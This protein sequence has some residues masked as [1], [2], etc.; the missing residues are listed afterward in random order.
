MEKKKK[1]KL[2][3][4]ITLIVS[5]SI[6][7]PLIFVPFSFGTIKIAQ[8]DTGGKATDVIVKDEIAYV[9]DTAD[10]NPGGLVMINVSKKTH[11]VVVGTYLGSGTPWAIDVENHIAYLANYFEGLEIIDVS[12]PSNPIKIGSYYGSGHCTDVQV[13][14]NIVYI[15]DWSYG[16]VILNVSD[17]SNVKEISHFDITGECYQFHVRTDIACILDHHSSYTGLILLNVSDPKNP[18]EIGKRYLS[19]VDYWNPFLVEHYVYVGNHAIDGG[20]LHILDFSSPADIFQV[21]FYHGGGS[22]FSAF[23]KNERAYLA[24]YEKGLIILDV[25][26]KRNPIK[27]AQFFNGGHAYDL[28]SEDNN[29]YV[30]DGEHGLEIIEIL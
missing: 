6:I 17:P 5:F 27:I 22:V 18:F 26:N 15:A 29:A 12:D 23:I 9:I 20:G 19:D 7:T 8:V 2:I 30:A 14:G 25:S 10:D 11:P 16:L 24:D 4:F 28:F 3:I 1:K 13:N 21:G